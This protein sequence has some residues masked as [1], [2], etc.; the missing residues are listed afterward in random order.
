MRGKRTQQVRYASLRP[1]HPRVRMY[2]GKVHAYSGPARGSAEF[3]E[4]PI[5]LCP[6]EHLVL[7][8]LKRAQSRPSLY[9]ISQL[10][11]DR[12]YTMRVSRY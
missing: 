4:R 8:D 7:T 5:I 6:L 10:F 12:A 11:I 3:R 9:P 1:R 2:L